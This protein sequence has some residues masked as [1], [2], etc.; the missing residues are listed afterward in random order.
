MYLDLPCFTIKATNIKMTIN[1]NTT[2]TI[3][4]T[5]T[6]SERDE[7]FLLSVTTDGKEK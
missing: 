3:M 2:V 1:R 6:P 4:A 5:L 7:D